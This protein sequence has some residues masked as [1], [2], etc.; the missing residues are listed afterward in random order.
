MRIFFSGT[1]SY[2]ELYARLY[3]FMGSDRDRAG[4][5]QALRQKIDRSPKI[6]YVNSEWRIGAVEAYVPHS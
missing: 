1:T 5:A 3:L 2:E 6:M 4:G